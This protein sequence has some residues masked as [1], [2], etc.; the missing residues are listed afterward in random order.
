MNSSIFDHLNNNFTSQEELKGIKQMNSTL[1][2]TE[3]SHPQPIHSKLQ[4]LIILIPVVG[5]FFLY[6]FMRIRN[7]RK[8]VRDVERAACPPAHLQP[9]TSLPPVYRQT[10]NTRP[11]GLLIHFSSNNSSHSSF[12]RYLHSASSESLNQRQRRRREERR[13]RRRRLERTPTPPPMYSV[14][15]P[16]AYDEI[17]TVADNEPLSQVQNRLCTH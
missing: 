2:E 3:T 11:S 6:S 1:G 14:S 9:P 12:W 8:R 13:R 7:R 15:S 4:W 5:A 17:T 10:N 16:P